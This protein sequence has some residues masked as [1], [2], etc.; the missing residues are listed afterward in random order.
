MSVSGA[1]MYEISWHKPAR[2]MRLTWLAG[3]E[4]MTDEDFRETLEVFAAAAIEH[5]AERLIIDVREFKHRP[6][7]EIL[8]WRDTTTVPKYNQAGVQ[9]LAWIWPG[10]VS[11]MKPSSDERQYGERYFSNESEAL[12]W[13]AE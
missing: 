12:A 11:S 3:T 2:L 4:G 5:R 10:D 8:A 7:A 6:S 13:L 1:P 9:K